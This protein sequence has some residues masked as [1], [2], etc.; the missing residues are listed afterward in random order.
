M[1]GEKDDPEAEAFVAHPGGLE[2][3]EF[4]NQGELLPTMPPSADF[5]CT[6]ANPKTLNDVDAPFIGL[7]REGVWGLGF[8]EGVE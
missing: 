7:L 1:M 5:H 6:V 2:A 8:R 3:V 4:C